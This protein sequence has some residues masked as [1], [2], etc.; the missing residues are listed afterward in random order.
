M[1]TVRTMPRDIIDTAAGADALTAFCSALEAA[2]LVSML[3]GSGPFTVLAPTDAAFG[4][5]ARH[6]LGDWLRPEGRPRLRAI[7]TY[8]LLPGRLP[9]AE[10][11]KSSSTPT[12]QGTSVTVRFTGNRMHVNNAAVVQADIECSNGVIHMIDTVVI[13]R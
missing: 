11:I 7:L 5:I 10:V 13:P 3:R 4:K 1:H 8:H 12:V 6:T 2:G 9:L